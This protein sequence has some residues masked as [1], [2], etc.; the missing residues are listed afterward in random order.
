MHRIWV[1]EI[2]VPI[3]FAGGQ[4]CGILKD[5]FCEGNGLKERRTN[6]LLHEICN[7]CES[8]FLWVKP[9]PVEKRNTQPDGGLKM[10][11]IN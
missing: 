7:N 5:F 10:V 11:V 2:R 9:L 4:A 1:E 3:R 6:P 8:V